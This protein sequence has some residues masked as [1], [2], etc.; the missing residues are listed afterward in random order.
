MSYYHRYWRIAKSV[1]VF[2]FF[3]F[4]EFR[5]RRHCFAF[6]VVAVLRFVTES[7]SHLALISVYVS[8]YFEECVQC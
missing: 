3:F 1:S 4:S 7:Q 8:Q 5:Q 2:S 6:G